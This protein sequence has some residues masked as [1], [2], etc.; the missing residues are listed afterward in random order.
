MDY[1]RDLRNMPTC[2]PAYWMARIAGMRRNG[3]GAAG[4]RRMVFDEK[5]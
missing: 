4:V 2:I 3:T 5:P 1:G